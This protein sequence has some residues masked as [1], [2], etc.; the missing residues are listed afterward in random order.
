M[1]VHGLGEH[2]GR[3]LNLAVNFCDMGFETHLIDLTG[4]GFSFGERAMASQK[5][6][7][8]D[9]VLAMR[10]ISTDMPCFLVGHSM[11]GGSI[12]A[13]LRLNPNLNLAGVI[14]SN[15]F[16]DYHKKEH[17]SDFEK[18]LIM[19]LPKKVLVR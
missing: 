7:F 11:G 17:V 3:N 19:W 18:T 6:L 13:F 4:F 10:E 16:I 15:P 14:C 8:E 12:L 2:S 5:E 9:I 1:F